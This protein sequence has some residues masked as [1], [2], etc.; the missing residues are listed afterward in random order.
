[1]DDFEVRMLLPN[2]LLKNFNING[3]SKRLVL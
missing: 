3:V 2:L 1:M